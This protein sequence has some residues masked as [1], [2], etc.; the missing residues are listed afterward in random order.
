MVMSAGIMAVTTAAMLLLV[1][2][3]TWPTVTAQLTKTDLQ[4]LSADQLVAINQLSSALSRPG[5][6]S[7]ASPYAAARIDRW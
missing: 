4:A 2:G 3:E 6:Q 5:S 1:R 7:P